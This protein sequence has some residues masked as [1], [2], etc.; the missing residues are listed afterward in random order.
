MHVYD[1]FVPLRNI[2]ENVHGESLSK[3]RFA[4]TSQDKELIKSFSSA[5]PLTNEI[6][7]MGFM[8][9]VLCL[10]LGVFFVSEHVTFYFSGPPSNITYIHGK[11]YR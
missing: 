5:K 3:R 11:L 8:E 1:L 2:M 9:M 4:L 6:A 10:A 7:I